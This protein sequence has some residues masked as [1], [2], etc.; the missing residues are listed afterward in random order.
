MGG[1]TPLPAYR[2]RRAARVVRPR[3]PGPGIRRRVLFVVASAA[4]LA[5][6]L[7]SGTGASASP[8]IPRTAGT[9]AFAD[10][11]ATS[12]RAAAVQ[13]CSNP[14][15]IAT[16]VM[17]ILAPAGGT[18]GVYLR[19]IGGPVLA[20][21]NDDFAYEPASSI[22]PLIALYALTQV[23]Q[24]RAQL[25]EQ[26]PMID[27][28]GG[29][30]DC[31]PGNFTGT[32]SLGYALQ[33]MLQVSDNNRTDELM[34]FFGVNNLNRFARSLGMTSTMFQTS[35][36][37]PGFNVIG[38]IS[39][40]F[41]PLPGTVDGNTMS[42]RDASILW[43]DIAQLPP[44]YAGTFYELAA[45]RDMYNT[46]GSDFTGVWPSMVTIADEEAP[47][48][49]SAAQLQSF[50]DH[51]TVSVKNGIYSLI[52]CPVSA[53]QEAT[54]WVFAGN[55]EIPACHGRTMSQTQYAWGD[56]IDDA[57][58]SGDY[59][60]VDNTVAGTA[61]LNASGQLLAA[62]I[63]EGLA[64]WASCAP[65]VTPTLALRG[66]G[67]TSGPDIGVTRALATLTDSDRTDI[68]ADLV[69]TVSWGDGSASSFAT[70]SG[71][72]G[73]FTVSGWHAYSA[74]GTY[75]VTITVTD[76]ESGKSTTVT[77]DITVT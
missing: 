67:V 27:D 8:L 31:P 66:R 32:E 61:F 15:A 51:M 25:S 4:S 5:I 77:E 45:G 33:Q 43:T 44:A 37:P 55:A 46:Q 58:E 20:A 18:H 38:C 60:N 21:V 74:P 12:D 48:G 13:P 72:D 62:P 16:C 73:S 54:W 65:A 40:G 7:G 1:R 70:I 2:P 11:T 64:S 42:L 56:F 68:P 22:K 23:E 47:A 9:A 59:T 17:N 34:Q 49:L 75:S 10:R 29:P 41:N 28:S 52:D 63:A 50:I 53:C 57:V 35:A 14:A 19:R 30:A 26:I 76:V 71:G 24:G 3:F 39:Y 6:A 36:S 69:G